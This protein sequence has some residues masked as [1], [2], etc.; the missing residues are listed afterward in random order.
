MAKTDPVGTINQRAD[1][2]VW[3]KDA[4]MDW[5]QIRDGKSSKGSSTS[6]PAAGTAQPG[7]E[8]P[9]AAHQKRY[10]LD[11]HLPDQ[12]VH[13]LHVQTDTEG[14]IDSKPVMT[15]TDPTGRPRRTYT[16]AFH[17]HRALAAR[18]EVQ[19]HTPA[20]FRTAH[21]HLKTRMLTADSPR[22][23][24]AA[25]VALLHVTGGHRIKDLLGV[26]AMHVA[27]TLPHTGGEAPDSGKLEEEVNIQKS[28]T[29]D[30]THE[31]RSHF[32]LQ[33]PHG[34]LFPTSHHDEGVA[35][36]LQ[37]R[38]NERSGAPGLFD[39]GPEH[40]Q[41]ELEGA[42]LGGA[43]ER[44]VRHHAAMHMAADKLSKLPKVSLDP[45]YDTG[46]AALQA[47]LQAVSDEIAEHFGHDPAPQGMSY[48]PPHIA[49]AYAEE[50][51]A[52]KHWPH[53]FTTK[54]DVEKSACTYPNGD[55][56]SSTARSRMTSARSVRTPPSTRTTSPL[57]SKTPTPSPQP[58]STV[59]SADPLPVEV[60]L[61]VEAVV[62]PVRTDDDYSQTSGSRVAVLPPK[63]ARAEHPFAGFVDYQGLEIDIENEAGSYRSGKD[64]AGNEWSCRMHAHY[65]EIR[66]AEG[67]DGDKLDAYVGPYAD[68]P[69]VVVVHQTNPATSKYD[70]DKVML[71]FLTAEEA[72]AMY[73]RQ[74]D[75]PGFYGGSDVMNMGE[76]RR[77]IAKRGGEGSRVE[78]GVQVDQP[79]MVAK[80]TEADSRLTDSLHSMLGTKYPSK[81]EQMRKR[82]AEEALGRGVSRLRGGELSADVLAKAHAH[83][84]A[85]AFRECCE[86][87]L[88]KAASAGSAGSTGS[89]GSTGSA[90]AT[91]QRAGR[92]AEAGS[93]QPGP[94][95]LPV[96]SITVL[97][98]GTKEQKVGPHEW[99]RVAEGRDQ[100]T[101][102]PEAQEE[103]ASATPTLDAAEDELHRLRE[104]RK[105]AA[106]PELRHELD[107]QIASM[108]KRIVKLQRGMGVKTEAGDDAR[109]SSRGQTA[110]RPARDKREDAPDENPKDGV[111]GEQA[112]KEL[113]KS[114][115][116]AAER[117]SSELP[118]IVPWYEAR[119]AAQA[120][121]FRDFAQRFASVEDVVI[122]L[123][124]AATEVFVYARSIAQTRG[125]EGLKSHIAK[126][127]GA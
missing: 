40:V 56:R 50:S 41:K 16:M 96:G 4:S 18:A 42:G 17:R 118:A 67:V 30:P 119:E 54:T 12:T 51:G 127:L 63:A 73:R 92:R 2:A 46:M 100:P 27:T 14:D 74:Y 6:T 71:G 7:A 26:H 13:P 65:G 115:Q 45:D 88:A 36:H 57:P 103:E 61:A 83:Y 102:K 122:G 10:G 49:A 38:V 82:K 23:R 107:L 91:T 68:S 90:G 112:K 48:V 93:G 55:T 31:H 32:I 99:R 70:E 121:A 116:S 20:T 117:Y 125:P 110:A 120:E 8:H 81:T 52:A 43:S 85:G 95:G 77:W 64:A 123:A 28:A 114:I 22:E 34:H 75:R 76:F 97:G 98:D 104:K 87:L 47:N 35:A 89:T 59:A 11:G 79:V 39:C 1:G 109:A 9:W 29:S 25:A 78:G 19:G 15:W 106:S 53:A 60:S 66:G 3:A 111:D 113:R 84:K 86:V 105:V 62:V 37:T 72:I 5:K 58:S 124:K 69:L 101:K 44:A 24:D 80:A 126:L 21:T 33:H 108:R 94:E